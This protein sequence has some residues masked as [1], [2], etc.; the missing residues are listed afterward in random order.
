MTSF[1][2][3]MNSLTSL[4]A[5]FLLLTFPHL[6]RVFDVDHFCWLINSMFLCSINSPHANVKLPGIKILMTEVAPEK[7]LLFLAADI[8]SLNNSC[9]LHSFHQCHILS[10]DFVGSTN[11]WKSLKNVLQ[12]SLTGRQ[13]IWNTWPGQK[14]HKEMSRSKDRVKLLKSV[15]KYGAVSSTAMLFPA[16]SEA[17]ATRGI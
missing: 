11:E 6:H 14:S 4:N 13:E 3:V 12:K 1:R 8:S 17:S 15:V 7:S 9:F 16:D 2:I 5:F 10:R